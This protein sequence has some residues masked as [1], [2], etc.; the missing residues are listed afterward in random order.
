[1]K[2]KLSNLNE[3]FDGLIDEILEF[4]RGFCIFN[5]RHKSS[6]KLLLIVKE[7]QNAELLLNVLPA[8][9]MLDRVK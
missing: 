1:M 3:E 4:F 6:F 9:N 8:E 5:L 7:T 2:L